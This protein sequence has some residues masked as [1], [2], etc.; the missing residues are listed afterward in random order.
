MP[1][2]PL[3]DNPSLENLRKQAKS[4]LKAVRAK[5]STAR[6][7]V[8][9]FHPKPDLALKDFSL[10]HAQNVIARSYGFAAWTKLK[11]HLD[12]LG[13]HSFLPPPQSE[14]K[15]GEKIADCFIRMACLSYHSADHTRWRDEARKLLAAH[16]GIAF[17]N[18]YTAATAGDVAA[19][20]KMLKAN[21]KLAVKRGGPY[22]WEPLLYAAYSRLNSEASE[23]ST[24]QVARL[25]LKHGADPN[26]GYLWDGHYV[27]TA[28]TGA[29]GEGEAGP[30]HQPEHQYCYELAR[31]LLKAG[32]DPN[33]SQTLYNRMF[34][35]GTRHLEMLFEFGL[36]KGGNG[37]WFKRLGRLME[38]PSQMLQQQMG[39]AAKYNQLERMRL[40]VKHGVDVNSADTRLKKTPY[41]LALL[42]GNTE[43]AKLLLAH[44]ATR[45]TLSIVDDFAATCLGG[46][47]DRA[48]SL[49]KKD[50]QL[51]EK[52]GSRRTELLQLAAERD[53][54]DAVRLMAELGFN[55]NAVQR[56]TGL[57]HA[58]MSG[59]LEM[60]KLLIE[61]GA[62]P[63]IRDTEF[64]AKPLG[65]AE[66]SNQTAV[67]EFLKQFGK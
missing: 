21:P 32:A 19:V 30:V 67:A 64:Q 14:S 48:R 63:H 18:I 6:A 1:A 42:H 24:L 58:A 22:N 26:A 8:L 50:P 35:G 60:A 37:V 23:H 34:T 43:I 65:W 17:E 7:R 39:W 13:R 25:L 40:L 49:L 4:L 46:N 10:S 3:P 52:L 61:L 36:G 16:P 15:D 29:F 53:K 62:D 57:H 38:T 27:F 59:H 44:G 47:A 2:Q 41:E 33:D 66:Y 28:L 54:R 31:L 5:N 20:T 12:V 55:L 11:N 45:T 9:E 51:I 56:T